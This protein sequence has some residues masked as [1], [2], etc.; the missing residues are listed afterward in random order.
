[1]LGRGER[2]AEQLRHGL[3]GR[4]PDGMMVRVS[5]LSRDVPG[6][7]AAQHAFIGALL[8]S[9]GAEGAT[10]LAGRVEP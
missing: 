1:V 4:L 3:A 2:L 6:A 7:Y 9:A 5:S 10:R 8:A